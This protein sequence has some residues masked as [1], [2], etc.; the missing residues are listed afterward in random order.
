[1]AIKSICVEQVNSCRWWTLPL[2][3]LGSVAESFLTKG[4]EPVAYCSPSTPSYS[5]AVLA[6]I[7]RAKVKLEQAGIQAKVV[8]AETE[9]AAW[10]KASGSNKIVHINPN[11]SQ[12]KLRS[13]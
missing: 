13:R 4:T 9:K 1:M 11:G 10:A 3:Y 5:Q 8:V 12:T 2:E 7:E 6:E